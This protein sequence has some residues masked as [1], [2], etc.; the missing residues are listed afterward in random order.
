MPER[1]PANTGIG[2]Q[3][4]PVRVSNYFRNR[5]PVKP[6]LSVQMTPEYAIIRYLSC[7][8]SKGLI[9]IITRNTSIDILRKKKKITQIALEEVLYTLESNEVPLADFVT[10]AEGYALLVRS[11]SQLDE[12]YADILQLKYI[13][14]YH[15]NEIAEILGISSD[16]ARVRLHRAKKKLREIM[17]KEELQNE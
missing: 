12:K 11:I 17:G 16:N 5:C 9:V 1:C 3:L 2:V 14:D 15:D 7:N 13:Y 4:K 8:K 10:A 6:G